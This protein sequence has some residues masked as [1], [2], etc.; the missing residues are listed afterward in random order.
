MQSRRATKDAWRMGAENTALVVIDMQ[1]AF[2]DKGSPLECAGA[3]DL[4]PRINELTAACRSLRIP[5]MFVKVDSRADLSDAGL[6]PEF[7]HW[8]QDDEMIPRRGR[9]G[10]EFCV[11]LN[12]SD[13]DYIVPKIRYSA[14]IPGSSGLEPLLR[15]LGRD[16]FMICGVA[17]DVCVGATAM[18]AMMLGF[19]VFFVG[20]LTATFSEERQRIALEVYDRHFVK[21]FLFRQAMEEL[22][23]LRPSRKV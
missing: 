18:D 4:L 19:K 5:V 11:G 17:T 6:S 13:K 7:A 22:T 1:R 8:A 2:V 9:K 23:H 15:G 10:N 12:V 14:F 16:R 3:E 21:V 20:D